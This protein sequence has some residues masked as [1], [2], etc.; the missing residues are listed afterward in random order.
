[1]LE[2]DG[3]DR[4]GNMTPRRVKRRSYTRSSARS[5][6]KAE[7][8]KN[9]SH[10]RSSTRSYHAG[11]SRNKDRAKNSHMN[12]VNRLMDDQQRLSQKNPPLLAAGAS[13]FQN[14]SSTSNDETRNAMI[15]AE[16]MYGQINPGFQNSRPNSMV[17]SI[18]QNDAS[19]TDSH[20]QEV[21]ITGIPRGA[22]NSNTEQNNFSNS[23]PQQNNG[24]YEISRPPSALT[25]YSNFHPQRRPLPTSQ[26]GQSIPMNSVQTHI[27]GNR[28]LQHDVAPSSLGMSINL[29]QENITQQQS[30][31]NRNVNE[32]AT[33]ASFDDDLPPP[34]PPLSSSPTA[35][36]NHQLDA[37]STTGA[38]EDTDSVNNS[39]IV[40]AQSPRGGNLP[41]PLERTV[42]ARRSRNEYVNIPQVVQQIQQQVSHFS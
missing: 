36:L 18:N 42:A 5:A 38:E 41:V 30:I 33:N 37:P 39:S 9:K 12:P 14:D 40:T 2:G 20:Q 22:H 31:N 25:S 23:S 6:G 29:T 26:A 34:P 10:H 21:E 4:H 15:A 13:Q 35:D 17:Y 32:G 28:L 11:G 3:N 24:E 8:N 16:R 19:A 7:L 1:M 27:A